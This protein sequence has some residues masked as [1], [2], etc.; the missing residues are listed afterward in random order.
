MLPAALALLAAAAM[1]GG[2][3]AVRY[4]RGPA[5]KPPAAAVRAA[6]A[7]L[8]AAG[9][10]VLLL[11]LRRGL[12]PTQMGTGGFAATAAVLLGFALLFGLRLAM[13]AWRRRRP[14]EGLVGAHAG[15][16]VAALVLLLA[17][18]TLR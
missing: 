10:A 2:G 18:L 13:L 4:F 14:S 6:H 1:L 17:V 15:L 12:P 8:G 5:A 9:L 7:A 3:L 16:A 11:A